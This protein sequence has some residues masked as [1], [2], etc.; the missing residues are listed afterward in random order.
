MIRSS[1]LLS[2][3]ALSCYFVSMLIGS[4][5]AQVVP[6]LTVYVV[7]SFNVTPFY[8]GMFFVAVAAAHPLSKRLN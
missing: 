3:P 5:H 6:T 4:L 8:L 7:D 1:A 2:G